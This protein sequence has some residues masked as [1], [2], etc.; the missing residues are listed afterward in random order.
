MGFV[1]VCQAIQNALFI[2]REVTVVTGI[3]TS[4]PHEFPQTFDQ[5]EVRRIRRKENN[6]NAQRLRFR[7]HQFATLVSG[8]VHDHL[9]RN[10]SIRMSLPDFTQQ[11]ANRVRID[12]S[13]V[14]HCQQFLAQRIDCS[15][16]IQPTSA[17]RRLHKH[18][19]FRPHRSHDSA[20]DKVGCIGEINNTQTVLRL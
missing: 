5:V 14:D 10:A 16:H 12:I 7:F 8:V 3:Q 6:L 15:Q 18:P 4:L 20:H 9:H 19:F 13:F 17:R 2:R 11:L 1:R